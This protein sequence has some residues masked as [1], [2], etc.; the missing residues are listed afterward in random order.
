MLVYKLV[1]RSVSV[2]LVILQNMYNSVL[3][4]VLTSVTHLTCRRLIT[5][6]H[7][8]VYSI[9]LVVVLVDSISHNCSV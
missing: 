8:V 2:H 4:K 3:A 1:V 6:S 7:I 9:L 5:F